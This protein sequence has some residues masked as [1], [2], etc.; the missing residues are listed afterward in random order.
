MIYLLWFMLIALSYMYGGFSA[1]RVVA[2]SFRSLNIYR[3]GTGLADTENIYQNVSKALGF[4]VGAIDVSKSYFYLWLLDSLLQWGGD[5]KFMEGIEFLYRPEMIMVYG[6][7][8]LIG[9]C[10]PLTHGF[11]GGRGIFTYM[12][13]IAYV[14]F[15]PMMITAV[16][17]MLS[18]VW[19]KQIRFAQYLIV[20][21]PVIL[22]QLMLS[23]FPHYLK[24]QPSYSFAYMFGTV[25]LMGALN[26][27][28]SKRLGEI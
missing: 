25:I 8:M 28:V 16:L 18:V 10:L 2:K 27:I 15:M 4:L 11:R 1:A 7:A 26:V 9:H 12:G 3:V 20:V 24:T 17:A 23:F 14:C 13:F 5:Y 19:F 6:V 22:M 21:F